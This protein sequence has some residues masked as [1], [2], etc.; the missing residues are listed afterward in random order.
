MVY[1]ENFYLYHT[2]RT[3]AQRLRADLL[4]FRER[5]EAPAA[6]NAE[7]EYHLALGH[8]HYQKRRYHDALREYKFALGLIYKYVAPTFQAV[9]TLGEDIRLPTAFALLEPMLDVVLEGLIRSPDTIP[10]IVIGPDDPLGPLINPELHTYATLGVET[11]PPFTDAT[12]ELLGEIRRGDDLVETG[13][14]DE[15]AQSYS[16]ALETLGGGGNPLVRADIQHNMGLALGELGRTEEAQVELVGAADAYGQAGDS[17]S[18]GVVHENMATLHTR[19]GNYDS[20]LAALDAAES[21]YGS[22]AGRGAAGAGPQARTRSEKAGPAIS[23][24]ELNNA[25][26]RLTQ[27]RNALRSMGQRGSL[28]GRVVSRIRRGLQAQPSADPQFVFK[29]VSGGAQAHP[30]ASLEG[31]APIAGA[32]TDEDASRVLRVATGVEPNPGLRMI[33]VDLAAADRVDRVQEQVYQNRIGA[34]TLES[35][36]VYVGAAY[37]PD[38]FKTHV[39]HHYFFTIQV[40]LGDVYVKLGQYEKA[41]DHYEKARDYRYLNVAIEAPNVWFRIAECLLAWGTDFYRHNKIADALTKFR[42]IVEVAIDGT[43]STPAA[44]PLY[45]QT[46]FNGVQPAVEAFIA[47]MDLETPPALNPRMQIVLRQARVYQEMIH[48][49]LNILGLPLD[50]VPI[51]RFRYLQTVARYFA[52]QAIKAEREY[53]NFLHNSE[54]EQANVLQLEQSV[55]LASEVVKLENRRVEEAGLEEDVAEAARDLATERATN[56]QQRRNEY[57]TVSADKVALDTATA[58]AS[59]GFT[60][61][62]G[63]YQVHLSTSGG[64]VHLGDEDYEIMRSA[65]WHRGQI[66]RKFELADMQRTIDEYNAHVAVTDAQVDL[67]KKRGQVAEQNRKIAKLRLAQA[68]ETLEFAQDK[69]LN[70]ELWGNLAERMREF[71]QLYLERATEIALLMEAA[72]NF[73]MDANLS[74]ISTSYETGEALGGLLGADTLLSDI[75]YF[76]YHF[77]TQTKS[78]EIPVKTILSLA[79]RSPFSIYRF[80]RTGL[81]EFETTLDEFDRLY[82]GTHTR[83]IKT[84]EVVLEGLIGAD[85][86]SGSL[87]NL[88]VSE[89]RTKDNSVK[90]RIQPRETLLLSTYSVKGDAIVFQPSSEMLG[91]FEG[92]GVSTGW[93]LEFPRGANDLNYEAISDVKLVLYYTAHHDPVLEQTIRAA[94]PTNGEW[95]RGLSLRFNYPDAFFLMLEQH[96]AT[97]TTTR[98]DFPYNHEVTAIQRIAFQ[99]IPEEGFSAAA[100]TFTIGNTSVAAVTATA[101][102]DGTVTSDPADATNVLNAFHGQTPIDTWSIAMDP[103]ANPALFVEE[104]AGSGIMRLRGIREIVTVVDYAYNVRV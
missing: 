24:H 7:I 6:R 71:A 101:D 4:D 13:Q 43:R 86:V 60:E 70:A 18:Q 63:G 41:L 87:R 39:P 54:Q 31:R 8:E 59:G 58:H 77:I 45:G 104:P 33:E 83:K 11:I 9:L 73:E 26:I 52:E 96:D 53:I 23:A 76:T 20:A 85:G 36:G 34:T 68:E 40:S 12:P 28:F 47:G 92:S 98:G 5:G 93:T 30:A 32:P 90:L 10:P 84:V 102:A 44:S 25:S 95:S 51:F 100:V 2:A 72:Y 89:F 1:Q 17:V 46:P 91:V 21:H 64:S 57:V 99:L 55:D 79:A 66:L 103:A 27:Q 22:A 19:A 35:L 50:I 75:N 88:G 80:R 49:G 14:F 82:P 48:A 62:E 42:Q 74:V 61:T 67:A 78:K 81:L 56:A 16:K 37:L 15:A 94:L 3:S 97:F 38:Y 65:A 29:P 69:T